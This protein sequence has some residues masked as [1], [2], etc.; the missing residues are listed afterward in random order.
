MRACTCAELLLS[1][2]QVATIDR[3][4]IRDCDADP[5][6]RPCEADRGVDPSPTPLLV[7]R[8]ESAGYTSSAF[9]STTTDRRRPATSALLA[10]HSRSLEGKVGIEAAGP[11]HHISEKA[12]SDRFHP[13]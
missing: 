8:Q 9:S 4:P 13:P 12:Q 6:R 11:D 1:P 3:L 7:A 10:L 5:P 2:A